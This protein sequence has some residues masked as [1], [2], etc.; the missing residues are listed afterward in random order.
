MFQAFAESIIRGLD[1]YFHTAE[2]PGNTPDIT[3]HKDLVSQNKGPFKQDFRGY[4]YIQVCVN[5]KNKQV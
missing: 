4:L 3:E 2:V 5:P 1:Q